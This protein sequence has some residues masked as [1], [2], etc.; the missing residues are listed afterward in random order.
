MWGN[1]GII[2]DPP[3]AGNESVEHLAPKGYT[4]TPNA[5]VAQLDRVLP[6]EG[7]G[8]TFESSRARQRIPPIC[9]GATQRAQ[10]V[11]CRTAERFCCGFP[12]ILG[13][14]LSFTS[15]AQPA[16]AMI[17]TTAEPHACELALRAWRGTLW[18][19]R[20]WLL[21]S[22]SPFRASHRRDGRIR[23]PLAPTGGVVVSAH[24]QTGIAATHSRSSNWSRRWRSRSL[25]RRHRLLPRLMPGRR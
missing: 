23:F 10:E 24:G 15:V 12:V 11:R 9:C 16:P 3:G 5:P 8:R 25:Q 2:G 1:R 22:G 19:R 6:S 17:P 4:S 18:T 7:R 20:R 13:S 21:S 14:S